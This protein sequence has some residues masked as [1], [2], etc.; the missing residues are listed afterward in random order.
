MQKITDIFVV[1]IALQNT[2]KR[3]AI[4]TTRIPVIFFIFANPFLN[5]I[6]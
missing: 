3:N 4:L 1:K 5:I 2:T 6:F